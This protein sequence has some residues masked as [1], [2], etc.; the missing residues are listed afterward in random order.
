[1]GHILVMGDEEP[2]VGA[3][4]SQ[5]RREGFEAVPAADG[6]ADLACSES[7]PPELVIL[8]LMVPLINGLVDGGADDRVTKPFSV[9]ELVTRVRAHLRRAG[10]SVPPTESGMLVVGPIQMDT[11]RHE[12]Y[13]HRGSVDL[14][15]KEFALLETLMLRP[16]K[17]VTRTILLSEVWGILLQVNRWS[18]LCVNLWP[19]VC[20]FPFRTI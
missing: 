10:M 1:M 5:L 14:T 2:L 6:L 20:T 4:C 12:V 15:G 17:L 13:A 7:S 11:E 18:E 16:G 8:D 9:L 19:C 3:L